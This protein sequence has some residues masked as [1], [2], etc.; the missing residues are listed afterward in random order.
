MPC[1]DIDIKYG[2][3]NTTLW[4]NLTPTQV[5]LPLL[6]FL[7]A[8]SS[9]GRLSSCQAALRHSWVKFKCK[10]IGRPAAVWGAAAWR[11]PSSST[12]I[13]LATSHPACRPWRWRPRTR[14]ERPRADSWR[15]C[16]APTLCEVKVMRSKVSSRL[17]LEVTTRRVDS[18]AYVGTGQPSGSFSLT[19]HMVTHCMVSSLS[20]PLPGLILVA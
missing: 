8:A 11:P 5:R 12:T 16:K 9:R 13:S 6:S 1:I 3:W 19:Q 17:A 7:P 4:Q 15:S 18:A 20:W 2:G 10:S 14:V